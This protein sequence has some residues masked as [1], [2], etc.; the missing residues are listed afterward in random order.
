MQK[1]LTAASIVLASMMGVFGS[2]G[3]HAQAPSGDPVKIGVVSELSGPY[4]FYGQ[5]CV[6]GM[7]MAEEEINAAGGVLKRPFQLVIVDNQTSPSQAVAAA[8]AVDVN[9]GVVALTGPASSD[10]ALAIYGYAEQ[11]KIPFIVPVA[12]FA[13]LTK[14]GTHY[15]FRMETDQAS[16]GH[17]AALYL[18]KVKP[19]AKVAIAISDYAGG[20]AL[21]AG[22]RYQAAKSGITITNDITFPPNTT[23]GRIQAAQI[24]ASHPDFVFFNMVGAFD[25]TIG[26]E[27]LDFGIKPEQ[28]FRPYGIGSSIQSWGPRAVGSVYGSFFDKG[29]DKLT[30]EGKA[31]VEKFTKAN[32]RPPSFV[33]NF[34][35][36]TAF[37]FKAAIDQAGSTDREKVRD[38][39]A[40]ISVA[41]PTTGN[42]IK[43]DENGA[44]TGFA[45]FMR[46][47]KTSKN[48]YDSQQLYY[49]EWEPDSIPVYELTK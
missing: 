35:Y 4:S 17:A 48:D 3:A 20:R 37:V 34:C 12:A 5:S 42:I 40:H 8:R 32:G 46:L 11:N 45:Y 6:L 19:G 44:R 49:G 14:P 29:I 9:D 47:L 33:E 15:T 39:I 31:F 2:P 7:K 24:A 41:E 28:L 27:L 43:F 16:L 1:M 23:D 10:N 38:A 22:F 26:N 21:L 36:T 30:P 25:V 13:Q 18:A